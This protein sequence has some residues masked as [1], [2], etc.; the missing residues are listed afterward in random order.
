VLK[1]LSPSTLT[2]PDSILQYLP[3]LPPGLPRTQESFPSATGLTFDPVA[4]AESAADL[5]L[6]LV[7]NA[8]RANRLVE[9]HA[10]D[11]AG[12][13]LNEVIDATLKSTGSP[14]SFSGLALQVK[15]AVDDR[16]LEALLA[17]GANSESSTMTR[18][19]VRAAVTSLRDRLRS[20]SSDQDA[21]FH[22][23]ETYRI[24]QFL[25]NPAKFVPAE[26]IAAPPGMPIGD[27]PDE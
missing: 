23:Q 14:E 27:D 25:N 3:P 5:S 26:P 20:S 24:D 6:A 1:T 8:Q 16:I 2:L 4:A 22:A 12:P 10:E 7:F 21:A 15:Y 19:T 18:A 9:F 11:S 13:S 17:L